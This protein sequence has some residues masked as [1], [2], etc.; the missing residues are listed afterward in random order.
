M[1]TLGKISQIDIF[2]IK[3]CGS[4]QVTEAIVTKFGLAHPEN[5]LVV[6]R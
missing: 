6:D 5:P 3:S 4:I 1:A 2:P